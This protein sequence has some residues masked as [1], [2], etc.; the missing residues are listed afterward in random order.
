MG[1]NGYDVNFF[2]KAT[3]SKTFVEMLG[4]KAVAIL[5]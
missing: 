1:G 5:E 3:E 4:L 2:I